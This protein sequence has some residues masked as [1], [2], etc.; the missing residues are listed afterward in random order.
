MWTISW[1]GSLVVTFCNKY[2]PFNLHLEVDGTWK[3]FLFPI[4]FDAQ[5]S[6][7]QRCL[8]RSQNKELSL[9][10]FSMLSRGLHLNF[11]EKQSCQT[12]YVH[13]IENRLELFQLIDYCIHQYQK[14]LG[15][16]SV[17]ISRK[18]RYVRIIAPKKEV[19]ISDP[20]SSWWDKSVAAEEVH[21]ISSSTF[22]VAGWYSSSFPLICT[23]RT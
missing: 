1:G 16:W 10:K 3:I 15:S 13:L 22:A 20:Y 8:Y 7:L 2:I 19:L 5:K 18:Q 9:H 14:M 17:K 21:G 23:I 12:R 6:P 11:Q 4:P